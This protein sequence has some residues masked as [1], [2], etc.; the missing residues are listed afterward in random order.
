MTEKQKRFAIIA[1]TVIAAVLLFLWFR[2]RGTAGNVVVEQSPFNLPAVGLGPIWL[3]DEQGATYNIP[4][5]N[6]D[7][8]GLQMIGACC[9]DCMQT[10]PNYET[11]TFA[12]PSITFNE[13][14][15]GPNVY[16]YYEPSQQPSSTGGFTG[17][18]RG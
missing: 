15:N 6:L 2:R 12:G 16:N 7:G 18:Y 11:P 10:K 4:G 14:N 3:P 1:G 5:L 17:V 8:P 13:G 9:S